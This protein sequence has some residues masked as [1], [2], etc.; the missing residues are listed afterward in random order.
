[1]KQS[2][3]F[4][5][6]QH[7]WRALNSA[8]AEVMLG[9][10]KLCFPYICIPLSHRVREVE[11]MMM[12]MIMIIKSTRVCLKQNADEGKRIVCGVNYPP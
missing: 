9:G 2:K 11:T 1:M 12:I 4:K 3:S 6:A 8:L 7:N 10:T 5:K